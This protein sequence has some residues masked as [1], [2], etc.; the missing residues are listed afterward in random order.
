M[1]KDFNPR[2]KED[3]LKNAVINSNM[4]EEDLL[5]IIEVMKNNEIIQKHPHSIWQGKNGRHYT[6]I[7]DET[8][9][10]GRRKIAKST[11]DALHK[12]IV[13]NYKQLEEKNDKRNL[14]LENLYEKWLIWRRDNGTDP[15]TIKADFYNWKRH[16]KYHPLSKK[17]ICDI[18]VIDL[19]DFFNDITK[20]HA[21]T[22]KM[23][24]N[25]RSVLSGIYQY[26]LRENVVPHSIV[27]DLNYTQYRTRCKPSGSK[28]EI[29]TYDELKAICN[30]VE[31]ED[32]VYSLAIAFSARNLFRIGETAVIKKTNVLQDKLLIECSI[33]QRQNLNDD[34]TFG[35]IYYDIEGRIKGNTSAG[36][37]FVNL[38][39][40]T[41]EIAK[42]AMNLHPNGEYLFMQNGKPIYA[43]TFNE[44]LKEVCEKLKI[45]YRSSHQ[46]RYTT[47]T[48]LSNAGI[49]ISEISN[50]MGHSDVKQTYN[51]IRQ[52]EMS[53]QS[54]A[55][56]N[57]V[58][59]LK[60]H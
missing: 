53:A 25:V 50:D 17:K 26:A 35:P 2:N 32:D 24:S 14:N 39:P 59:D 38:T 57:Q 21:I 11:V 23:L 52:Q 13:S 47:A 44:K 51:Y 15:N 36:I 46:F 10:E 56:A 12:A 37:R 43:A 9:P 5:N 54:K 4:S 34:L 45:K 48:N 28:K 31:K 22:F 55:I 16:L 29:Y 33:R 18:T 27:F 3:A 58:Q 20:N 8:M 60:G 30:E 7:N 1:T 41:Q 42:K 6:H 49:P 40:E 19:E